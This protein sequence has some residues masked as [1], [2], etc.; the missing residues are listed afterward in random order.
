M[1][2]Q[3]PRRIIDRFTD[4]INTISAY[5]QH[6]LRESIAGIDLASPDVARVREQVVGAMDSV[7]GVSTAGVGQLSASFYNTAR[8]YE[9]GHAITPTTETG[10]NPQATEGAVRAF[11]QKL[12]DGKYDEF[13]DLCAG[14]IDYECKVAAAETCLNNARRDPK[15]PRFARVP[16]GDETCDFCLMLA[17][18]GFVYHNE[19]TAS[20]SHENCDCRIVP[21]WGADSVEDYDPDEIR[22]RWREAVNDMAERRAERNGTTVDEERERIM[23]G[24]RQSSIRAKK[25]RKQQR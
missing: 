9:L 17:S 3:L 2:R 4:G 22:E 23:D 8:Q 20:H 5:G 10:R 14:R 19:V 13:V 11:A 24:Y 6:V 1:P 7:C 18:N 25:R 12:V 15:P 16:A 21:S